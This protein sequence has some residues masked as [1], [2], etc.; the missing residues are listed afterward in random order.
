MDT[1]LTLAGIGMGKQ[2][3]NSSNALDDPASGISLTPN[4]E[5]ASWN[6]SGALAREFS[7]AGDMDRTW[8][9][10]II[11]NPLNYLSLLKRR[12][13]NKNKLYKSSPKF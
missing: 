1:T 3:S 9:M 5:S 8:T 10:L 7:M 11:N 4:Q 13:I 6:D 2:F 12:Q